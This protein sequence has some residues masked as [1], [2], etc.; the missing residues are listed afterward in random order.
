MQWQ[1]WVSSFRVADP[2]KLGQ[3][4]TGR[5]TIRPRPPEDSADCIFEVGAAV[6]VWWCDGWWEG[7]VIMTNVFGTNHLQIYLP[8]MLQ[9]S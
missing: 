5:L 9:S 1:E 4:C 3:R 7:V 2:D 6:D 8:G